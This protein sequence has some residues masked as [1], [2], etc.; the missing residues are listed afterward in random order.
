MSAVMSLAARPGLRFT[1][2][3]QQRLSFDV[4]QRHVAVARGF[5]PRYQRKPILI[6][7]TAKPTREETRLTRKVCLLS[8]STCAQYSQV[9]DVWW[10]YSFWSCRRPRQAIHHL[11][12]SLCC[13]PLCWDWAQALC[14]S[15]RTSLGRFN[16]CLFP[17]LSIPQLPFS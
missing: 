2:C 11:S 17:S 7:C 12:L 10:Q 16:S 13:V 3:R 1:S 9:L 5:V 6:A 15:S 4:R 14:L 8:W